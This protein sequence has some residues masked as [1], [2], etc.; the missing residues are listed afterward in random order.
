[1]VKPLGFLRGTAGKVVLTG[2]V[3]G[4]L[5]LVSTHFQL[6]TRLKQAAFATGQAGGDVITQPI[7][8]LTEALAGG[9]NNIR[10]EAQKLFGNLGAAGAD[11]QEAFTGNRDAIKDFFDGGSERQDERPPSRDSSAKPQLDISDTFSD[12]AIRTRIINADAALTPQG[13]TNDSGTLR[14][15]NSPFKSGA[16]QENALQKAIADAAKL[17]PEYFK[18]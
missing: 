18:K 4:G 2:G 5:Y 11:V 14:A 6:G 17:F 9:I 16:E 8:G 12:I 1:M 15:I 13:Y 7:A 3:I 10:L